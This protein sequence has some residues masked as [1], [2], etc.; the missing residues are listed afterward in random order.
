MLE[1]GNARREY[2]DAV[3]IV[4]TTLE[5]PAE[6]GPLGPVWWRFG[7]PGRH[8]LPDALDNPNDRAA[9]DRRQAA[10]E[11]EGPPGPP[12]PDAAPGLRRLRAPEEGSTWE[13]RP[14]GN[15]QWTRRPGSRC[16]TCHQEQERLEREAQEHLEAARESNA[17]LRLCWTCRGSIGG[18]EGS[19][20]ELTGQAGSGRGCPGAN[21]RSRCGIRACWCCPR[22]PTG[23][24]W[25]R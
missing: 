4:T 21:G 9:Y 17:A 22:R 15:E 7:R 19:K 8:S 11:E 24:R 6:H 5:L 16:W 25:P 14:N 10:R 13:Y 18:K 1:N 2:D 3:P 23:S 20:L 12:R